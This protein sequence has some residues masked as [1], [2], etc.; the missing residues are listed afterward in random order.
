MRAAAIVSLL[1][2]CCCPLVAREPS[3]VFYVYVA[4]RRPADGRCPAEGN[5][6]ALAQ[7]GGYLVLVLMAALIVAAIEIL[8][9]H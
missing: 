4:G 3:A 9:H 5:M 2:G 6:E 7:L 1:G 8:N